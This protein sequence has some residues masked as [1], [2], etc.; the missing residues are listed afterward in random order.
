LQGVEVSVGVDLTWMVSLEIE[1]LLERERERAR[2]MEAKQ[3]RESKGKSGSFL[4]CW[5]FVAM[6]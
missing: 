1:A 6:G 4:G 2:K 3:R 5:S